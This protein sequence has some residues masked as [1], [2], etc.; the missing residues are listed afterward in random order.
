[1]RPREDRIWYWRKEIWLKLR[2]QVFVWQCSNFYFTSVCVAIKEGEIGKENL[3]WERLFVNF[4]ILFIFGDMSQTNSEL[5]FIFHS[6]L[7]FFPHLSSY[8]LSYFPLIYFFL[9]K[10]LIVLFGGIVLFVCFNCFGGGSVFIPAAKDHF[11]IQLGAVLE[12]LGR[13][14]VENVSSLRFRWPVY[15]SNK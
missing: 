15:P 13:Q 1:M 2:N 5:V 6:V 10:F 12:D 3:M 7:S 8:I 4:E 14:R 11:Q 9:P